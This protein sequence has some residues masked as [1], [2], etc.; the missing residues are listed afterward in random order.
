MSCSEF[1]RFEVYDDPNP[2][3]DPKSTHA[4]I[5]R[6]LNLT[7]RI[8]ECSTWCFRCI[9][10]NKYL[11]VILKMRREKKRKT[12]IK[13][14]FQTKS[15]VFC[16]GKVFMCFFGQLHFRSVASTDP[17]FPILLNFLHIVL[18]E[19]HTKIKFCYNSLSS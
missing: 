7:G 4:I 13:I 17:R 6:A 15:D 12:T 5:Q 10:K 1:R 3:V 2:N 18:N 16:V 9:Y 14:K 19:M 8:K 11:M